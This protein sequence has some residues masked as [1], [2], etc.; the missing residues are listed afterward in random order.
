MPAKPKTSETADLQRQ[1]WRVDEFSRAARISLAHGYVLI[2]RQELKAIELG[3][4][5]RIPPSEVA[6]KLGLAL[7]DVEPLRRQM[8]RELSN[9]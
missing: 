5:L 3:S 6:K 8:Q 4:T 2:K 7:E 9:A 1:P